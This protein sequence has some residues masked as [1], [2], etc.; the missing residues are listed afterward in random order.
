MRQSRV[1]NKVECKQ[2]EEREFEAK[3][4]EFRAKGDRGETSACEERQTGE[5]GW[6][7][8]AGR[9]TSDSAKSVC[10]T[11]LERQPRLA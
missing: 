10:E 7:S 11:M 5:R 3:E 2:T 4:C 9:R 8:R 1:R 6:Q